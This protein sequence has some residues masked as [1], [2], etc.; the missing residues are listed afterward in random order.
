M[1]TWFIIFSKFIELLSPTKPRLAHSSSVTPPAFYFPMVYSLNNR[2][3]LQS[4]DFSRSWWTI[5]YG[6]AFI[7][8]SNAVIWNDKGMIF[9]KMDTLWLRALKIATYRGCSENG[10]V[11]VGIIWRYLL[12]QVTR[13]KP[14]GQQFCCSKKL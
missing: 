14:F 7:L 1:E 9:L 10:N 8:T 5:H 6:I 13:K 11:Q 2:K 3:M 12:F 4:I